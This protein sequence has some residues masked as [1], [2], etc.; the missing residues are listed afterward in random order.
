MPSSGISDSEYRALAEFRHQLRRFLRSSEQAAREAGLEPQQQ[1]L[2]LA[3]KGMPDGILCSIGE[4]AD[5]LQI[6]HHSTVELVD[7]LVKRGYVHRRQN[8]E[9]RR[10]ILLQLTA[11]GEKTLQ[12][13]ALF[14]R[15]ELRTGVPRLLEVMQGRPGAPPSR[16]AK[17]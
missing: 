16:T 15:H 12:R 13:L 11:K 7:R 10:Q 3:V 14:H 5:R 8:G 9:D 2:L 4:V 1:Q 6:R 17:R